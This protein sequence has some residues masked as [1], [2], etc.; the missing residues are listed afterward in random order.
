MYTAKIDISSSGANTVVAAVAGRRIKVLGYTLVAAGAVTVK[1][2]S[3]TTDLSGAMALAANGVVAVAPGG[4]S[5]DPVPV[6]ATAAGEALK[7]TLGGAVAVAGHL[8][9]VI[10]D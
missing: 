7:I 3:D 4:D 2:Q 5:L 1:W 8:T 6:L 10:T 9:Y